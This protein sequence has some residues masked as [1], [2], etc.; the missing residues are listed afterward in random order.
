V[1]VLTQL[2]EDLPAI[3][4]DKVQLQQVILNLT[5]NAIEAMS[6]VVGE[7]K[8]VLIST[9]NSESDGVIVGV[10]DSG[11][12]LD[13][14]NIES[15]FNAF[16]TTKADGLGMGLSIC[17][18]IVEAH[19]GKLWATTDTPRGAVFQFSLPVEQSQHAA[20]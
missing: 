10:R 12:G 7:S 3:Q 2:G 16:Y 4:G 17:R 5:M 15:I 14:A 9:A 11:P 13:P 20:L 6:T 18:S 8:V 19:G 1:L